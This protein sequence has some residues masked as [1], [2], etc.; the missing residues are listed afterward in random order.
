MLELKA[1]FKINGIEM[2]SESSPVKWDPNQLA[3]EVQEK[4]QDSEGI[5][6]IKIEKLN[7]VTRVSDELLDLIANLKMDFTKLRQIRFAY[8]SG[9]GGALTR[10]VIERFSQKTT[11]LERLLVGGMTESNLGPAGKETLADLCA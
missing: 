10:P 3:L 7:H 9:I 4:L 8:W 1:T 5:F 11:N 2:S 6:K